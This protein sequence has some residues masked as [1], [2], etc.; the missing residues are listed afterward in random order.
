MNTKMRLMWDR[1]K[2]PKF[3]YTL[4]KLKSKRQ[5]QLLVKLEGIRIILV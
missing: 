3:S 2:N 4:I 5:Y 1:R